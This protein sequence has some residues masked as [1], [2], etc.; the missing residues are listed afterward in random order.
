MIDHQNGVKYLHEHGIVHRD[1]KPENLIL[2]VPGLLG[3]LTRA[4][5]LFALSVRPDSDDLVI[6][7]F[8]I[9]KH[10]AA[11]EV[12]TSIAG[13]P[14]YAAPEVLKQSGHGKPVDLWSIGFVGSLSSRRVVAHEICRIITYT[15]LCG[16]TP[17]RSTEISVLL[18][19]CVKAKIELL[20]AFLSLFAVEFTN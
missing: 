17:F 15:L 5:C 14:G 11:G 1:L 10:I 9:A 13:S 4:E 8:G 16:Y 19:G 3:W 20:V 6:A 18:Q 2:F 7:D 12:L